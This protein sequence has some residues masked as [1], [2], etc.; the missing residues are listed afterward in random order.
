MKT[1]TAIIALCTAFGSLAAD[2]DV[3]CCNQDS[4]IVIDD[5]EYKEMT[6]SDFNFDFLFNPVLKKNR[7]VS[8]VAMDFNV[9]LTSMFGFVGI[10]GGNNDAKFQMGRSIEFYMPSIVQ[11]RISTGYNTPSVSL[12]V[13]FGL[14]H[15]FGKN[16]S[17]FSIEEHEGDNR[18]V[19]GSYPEGSK[20]A[21]SKI[22]RFAITM[23]LMI[24]QRIGSKGKVAVGAMLDFN[25][26]LGA[27]TKYR[28]ENS[29]AETYYGSLAM[30][31]IT[32]ELMAAISS[33]S[34]GLYFKFLPV[35]VF[36]T[37]YGPETKNLSVGIVFGL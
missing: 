15:F 10:V 35:N 27:T 12:G 21:S 2:T 37:G 11:Y 30:R 13:G 17:N 9:K 7:S 19:M 8:R 33:N 6:E 3:P 26:H 25:T 34:V 16:G 18:L 20:R 31:T 24:E 4:V 32:Y 5:T 1:F 28:I 36:K 14:Q 23:P 29:R 22:N